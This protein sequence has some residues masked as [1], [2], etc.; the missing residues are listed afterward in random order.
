[1]SIALRERVRTAR[2]R[3]AVAYWAVLLGMSASVLFGSALEPPRWVHLGALFVHLG[4]VIV[5]LGGAVVLELIGL[6]W[7]AG[8]RSLDEVRR[9]AQ[10]VTPVAWIA[11]VGLLVSGAF[12]SPDLR[13]PPTVVKMVA[14]LVVAMNGVAMTRLTAALGRM[15]ALTPFPALPARVKLWCVWTAVLSQS[16]WWTAVII[17]MLNTAAP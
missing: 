7:M 4:A 6:Q 1:M 8:H 10:T 5:G 12:L 2:H 11:I 14:V 9:T 3:R 17:G 15:P 13:D 16:S